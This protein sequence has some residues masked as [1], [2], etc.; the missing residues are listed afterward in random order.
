MEEPQKMVAL[1]KAY[2]DIILNTAKEAAARVMMSERKAVHFEMDLN[3]TKDEALHLLVRLKQ[4]IDSKTKEAEITSSTKQ[5]KIDELEAQLCEAEDVITD[6]RSELKWVREKL[7]RVKSNQQPLNGQFT[8][9]DMYCCENVTVEPSLPSILSS[10]FA[11]VTASD[12]ENP[13]NQQILDNMSCSGTQ[14][15]ENLSVSQL[16]NYDNQKS[17]LASI[18]VRNKEPELYKNGCTQRIRALERNLL[19]ENL[20]TLGYVDDQHSLINNELIIDTSDK[21]EEKHP[22]PS[23]KSKNINIT[24][25]FPGGEPK[26]PMKVRTVRRR[27]TRFGKAKGNLRRSHA[28]Q[29]MKPCHFSSVPS[30]CKTYSVNGNIRSLSSVKAGNVSNVKNSTGLD[31]KMQHKGSFNDDEIICEWKRNVKLQSR[32]GP[33]TSFVSPCDQL[34]K[35]LETSSAVNRGIVYSFALRGTVKSGE[36]GSK[37]AENEAKMKPLPRLDP[38]LTLIRRG[39]DPV[40]GSTNFSVSVKAVTKSRHGPDA[41]DKDKELRNKPALVQPEGDAIENSMVTCSEMSPEMLNESPVLSDSKDAKLS[42]ETNESPSKSDSSK[43]LKYTFQRKR[44]KESMNN[45]DVHTSPEKSIVKRRAAEKQNDALEP[46]KSSLINESSRDSRRL[47]QVA[48]QL[49]SLSGRRW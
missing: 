48:R 21:H 7:E 18:I 8:E 26:K 40:S 6:L 4:M 10:G 17:N 19:T 24:K 34:I 37:I 25:K 42:I 2:A 12:V 33:S 39:A 13:L 45:S 16:E 32:D 30:H 43:F 36:D 29:L 3:R 23:P 28:G 9:V 49:I 27:R 5:R 44:K 20:P 31:E 1:K 35:P 41:F 15:T 14:Q 22:I 46:Q 47:A 11:T 38:G